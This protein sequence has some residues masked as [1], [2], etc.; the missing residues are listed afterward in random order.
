[1]K[2][3]WRIVLGLA[4][5][6]A[7]AAALA[8]PAIYWPVTGW[9]RGEAFY[10]GRPTS[11]WS[12]AIWTWG[13]DSAAG[14]WLDQARVSV[15]IRKSEPVPRPAVIGEDPEPYS[16]YAPANLLAM[17]PTE[18]DPAALPV[19][20]ELLGEK[21]PETAKKQEDDAGMP[22]VRQLLRDKRQFVR[23]QAGLAI[24]ALSRDGKIPEA[25][26][27]AFVG[28]ELLFI[29]ERPHPFGE[30]KD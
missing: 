4:L 1:M 17:R 2:R 3:P 24:M 27:R 14:T 10:Q 7:L 12:Q 30:A 9:L 13:N 29:L 6:V 16:W 15:G 22:D 25:D 18:V 19:L 26:A 23:I 20:L 5:L 21:R 28:E 11:Y 8:H